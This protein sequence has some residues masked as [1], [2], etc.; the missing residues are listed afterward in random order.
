MEALENREVE[1]PCLMA[2][3]ASLNEENLSGQDL[4]M[5]VV[6]NAAV[7]LVVRN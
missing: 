3:I 2:D 5:S 7:R 6:P 1:P 4:A